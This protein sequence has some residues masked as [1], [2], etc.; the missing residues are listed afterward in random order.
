MGMWCKGPCCPR[1][2]AGEGHGVGLV[3][4]FVGVMITLT[5]LTTVGDRLGDR[6]DA[7]MRVWARRHVDGRC[8]DR[9]GIVWQALETIHFVHQD[10]IPVGVSGRDHSA[11]RYVVHESGERS[12]GN[13][14]EHHRHDDF[15]DD[16][17]FRGF[18]TGRSDRARRR[19]NLR[20][21]IFIIW[22]SS[23]SQR[24]WR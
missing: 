9:K 5:V 19:S 21:E 13:R 20:N 18:R 11:L 23:R 12:D 24:C 4:P 1:F 10:A 6:Y 7:S 2:R 14:K 3:F 8:S 22:R 15:D 17:P 16:K